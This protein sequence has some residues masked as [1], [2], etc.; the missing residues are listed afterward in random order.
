MASFIFTLGILMMLVG[1]VGFVYTL[2]KWTGENFY[3]CK[4]DKYIPWTGYSM[5]LCFAGTIPL[6]IGAVMLETV[7]V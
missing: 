5:L 3:S 7:P 1:V 2:G 6:A 4:G